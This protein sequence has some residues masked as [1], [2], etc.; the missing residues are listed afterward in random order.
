M[1]RHVIDIV[2]PRSVHSVRLGLG[3]RLQFLLPALAGTFRPNG[4]PVTW[5][6]PISSN[7]A[8]FRPVPY[9]LRC[10]AQVTCVV[11]VAGRAGRTTVRVPAPAGI[12]C[13]LHGQNCVGVAALAP[14]GITVNVVAGARPS[15]TG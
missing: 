6:S 5:P 10:P 9:P 12:F 15:I 11:F 7:R 4:K 14:A 2:N 3:D 1:G 8:V 13:N